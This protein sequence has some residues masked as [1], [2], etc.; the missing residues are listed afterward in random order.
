MAD[1]EYKS[2]TSQ[3]G[4]SKSSYPRDKVP[5]KLFLKNPDDPTSQEYKTCVDCREYKKSYRKDKKEE[6]A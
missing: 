1:I 6:L 3:H 4:P 5:K 2:C